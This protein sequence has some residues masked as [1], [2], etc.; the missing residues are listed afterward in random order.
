VDYNGER[1]WI[2]A[3]YVTPQGVCGQ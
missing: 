2:S 3:S 1:G